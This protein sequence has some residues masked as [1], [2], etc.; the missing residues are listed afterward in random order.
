M[1]FLLM[2]CAIMLA[3]GCVTKPE[4]LP[5]ELIHDYCTKDKI[6]WFNKDETLDYLALNE[7]EFLREYVKHNDKFE[8]A[9]LLEGAH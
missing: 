8:A 6:L 3:S 7:P 2:T 5:P 4:K 9:C 1:R